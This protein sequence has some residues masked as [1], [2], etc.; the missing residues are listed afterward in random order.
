ME[1]ELVYE[2]ELSNASVGDTYYL[3]INDTEL[4]IFM[5]WYWENLCIEEILQLTDCIE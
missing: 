4:D 1:E 5:A 3:K 2:F